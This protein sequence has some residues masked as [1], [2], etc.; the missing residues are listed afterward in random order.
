MRLRSIKQ[1]TVSEED[2]KLREEASREQQPP[3]TFPPL[4]GLIW[5]VIRSH[6]RV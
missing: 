4:P 6:R 1:E 2:K 5:E 3:N